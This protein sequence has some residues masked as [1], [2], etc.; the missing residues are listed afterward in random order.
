MQYPLYI[1]D[2]LVRFVSIWNLFYLFCSKMENMVFHLLGVKLPDQYRFSTWTPLSTVSSIT[3]APSSSCVHL[4]LNWLWCVCAAQIGNS[5]GDKPWCR[6]RE[7]LPYVPPIC[8]VVAKL[9]WCWSPHISDPR[10]FTQQHHRYG[11]RRTTFCKPK[12][13]SMRNLRA[14]GGAPIRASYRVFLW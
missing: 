12:P 9:T 5:W 10:F 7:S 3:L 4:F 11:L 14:S 6:R 13:P 2:R 1:H 8:Q